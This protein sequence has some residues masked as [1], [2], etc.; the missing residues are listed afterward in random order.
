[1]SET[2]TAA[3]DPHCAT[4]NPGFNCFP[5]KTVD[6]VAELEHYFYCFLISLT[7]LGFCPLKLFFKE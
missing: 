1:M 6:K 3:L 5:S 4:T 7:D 2:V